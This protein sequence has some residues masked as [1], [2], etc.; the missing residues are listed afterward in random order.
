MVRREMLDFH[1]HFPKKD[2]MMTTL[3]AEY[4]ACVIASTVIYLAGR[5]LQRF[6]RSWLDSF[7]FFFFFCRALPDE[8]WVL[9][10]TSMT[11]IE[12]LN[13]FVLLFGH[14]CLQIAR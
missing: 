7:C 2:S 8:W 6:F 13:L 11:Q 1:S 14:L 5:K 12:G 3:C 9:C 4:R 10:E